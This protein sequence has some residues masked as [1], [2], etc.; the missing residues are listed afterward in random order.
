MQDLVESCISHLGSLQ[1]K[2]VLD[3]GCNDGSLLNAF[4]AKGAITLGVEPTDAYVEA[5]GRG[6]NIINEFFTPSIAERLAA[7]FGTPDIITFTNVFAHIENLPGLVDALRV[8]SGLE[9]TIVIENHYLGSILDKGQFDTF[10]HEHPRTYS[11]KSFSYIARQLGLRITEFTFPERYGG[12]IRVFMGRGNGIEETRVDLALRGK[13]SGES[14]FGERLIRLN[15]DIFEWRLNKRRQIDELVRLHGPLPA[16][17]F[18]GR[19][20]ILITLLG[21]SEREIS[22][23]YE[24]HGSMKIGHYLPGTKIQIRSDEEIPLEAPVIINF[25]WHISEEIRIYLRTLGFR[26]ETYNIFSPD[27]L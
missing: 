22:A 17:S 15:A 9:T 20:A 6:H 13:I 18:P 25:A 23:C 24:K 7:N 26:G 21:L 8:V 2:I 27:E 11:L 19:A 16:K 1:G 4:R 14:S 5:S 10:Y 12:N 3:V